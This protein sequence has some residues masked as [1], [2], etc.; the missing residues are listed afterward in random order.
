MEKS[1]EA[2]TSCP[3]LWDDLEETCRRCGGREI[4]EIEIDTPSHLAA[5]NGLVVV[6][7]PM[8]A[9]YCVHCEELAMVSLA[10]QCFIC[11]AVEFLQSM[12]DE[13]FSQ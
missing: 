12:D 13:I 9:C 10:Q 4:V 11:G 2:K 3:H 8:L 6:A 7:E 1:R 5:Q